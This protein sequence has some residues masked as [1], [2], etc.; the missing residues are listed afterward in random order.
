MVAGTNYISC[1]IPIKSGQ[2]IGILGARGTSTMYNSYAATNTYATQISGKPV[3][4]RR[5]YYQSSLYASPATTV[6]TETSYPFGRV[7]VRYT[8]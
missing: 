3:T 5:L 8:P 2:H 4:L 6:A 1:S 7:E